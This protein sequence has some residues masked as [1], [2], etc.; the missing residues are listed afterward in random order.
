MIPYCMGTIGFL[1]KNN[2]VTSYKIR[3]LY[4]RSNLNRTSRHVLI[5]YAT[6]REGREMGLNTVMPLLLRKVN[7]LIWKIIKMEA[8]SSDMPNRSLFSSWMHT[9]N[10]KKETGGWDLDRGLQRQYTG[11]MHTHTLNKWGNSVSA[12][13]VQYF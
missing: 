9:S 7:K 4:M 8:K 13:K 10:L 12:A 5:V 3:Y 11:C 1:A 2:V 6:N